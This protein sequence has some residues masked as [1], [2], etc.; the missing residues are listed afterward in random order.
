MYFSKIYIAKIIFLFLFVPV[1]F[2]QAIQSEKQKMIICVPVTDLRAECIVPPELKLPA[3]VRNN[4]FEDSQLLFNEYILA[5]DLNNGWLSIEAPEQWKSSPDNNFSFYTG[6]MLKSHAIAVQEFPNYNLVISST[7]AHIDLKEKNLSNKDIKLSA[8]TRL[9]GIEYNTDK[10]LWAVDIMLQD[11]KKYIGLIKASDVF[12]TP[13]PEEDISLTNEDNLRT[14]VISRAR[15]FLEMPYSW[16]GRSAYDPEE[17]IV[18]TSMDG[19]ALVNMVYRTLGFHVPRDARNQYVNTI[20]ISHGKDLK[21]GDLIFFAYNKYGEP[22]LVGS[23]AIYAGDQKLIE[24]QGAF[25]PYLSREISSMDHPRIQ[26]Q[27]TEI[28]SGTRITHDKLDFTIYFGSLL[29]SLEKR[30]D[31]RNRFLNPFVLS[32]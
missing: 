20:K 12:Q 11:N 30:K 31:M 7:W 25:E 17:K 3:F 18:F 10:A 2:I 22:Y 15:A 16:G 28:Q 13:Q 9:L 4:K 29:G 24:C 6:F 27:I 1:Y 32:E 26:K 5:Q 8:G 19:S 23:V 14:L 21:P